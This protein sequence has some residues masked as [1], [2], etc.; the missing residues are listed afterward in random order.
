MA[1]KPIHLINQLSPMEGVIVGGQPIPDVAFQAQESGYRTIVDLCAPNEYHSYDPERIESL[2]VRYINIPIKGE[3][4]LCHSSARKL[5]EVLENQAARP[6]MVHCAS[7][8]RVGALFALRARW[9]LGH[10]AE[11]ALSLGRQAGL[12]PG[13]MEQVVRTLI[14]DNLAAEPRSG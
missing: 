1:E 10:P 3:G 2:G 8:A 5:H 4:D 6:V 9:V 11:Q 14:Q 13:P 7:G 12:R